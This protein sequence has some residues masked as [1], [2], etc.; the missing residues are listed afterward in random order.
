M[1]EKHN[2]PAK[3]PMVNV[4]KDHD[5]E[6]DVKNVDDDADADVCSRRP[7][8]RMAIWESKRIYTSG[9]WDTQETNFLWITYYFGVAKGKTTG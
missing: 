2:N 6:N 1:I 9:P 7:L 8:G 5:V 3:K 4:L